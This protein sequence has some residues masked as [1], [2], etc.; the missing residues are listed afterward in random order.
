MRVDKKFGERVYHLKKPFLSDWNEEISS[1]RSSVCIS[2]SSMLSNQFR[3]GNRILL[4]CD[5]K[6]KDMLKQMG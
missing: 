6:N 3:K 1:H 2:L 5:S 4:F